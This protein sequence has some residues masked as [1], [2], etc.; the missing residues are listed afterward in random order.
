MTVH[1]RTWQRPTPAP[2]HPRPSTRPVLASTGGGSKGGRPPWASGRPLTVHR[3]TWQRP[4]PAP[5]HP[6]PS[7]TRSPR[8]VPAGGRR[9]VVPPGYQRQAE[10][11]C[12]A[13]TNAR[14]STPPAKH[15]TGPGQYRRGVEGGSS[16]LGIRKAVDRS[17]SNVHRRTWQRPTQ[18]LHTPAKHDSLSSRVPAGGEGGS[19]PLGIRGRRRHVRGNDQR[20]HIHTPGQAR[21]VLASTGGGSKGGRPPWVS[22]EGR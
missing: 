5:P 13:T 17:P 6:R 15:A 12:V 14:T 16:P 21:P 8:R 10:T 11:M 9:G 20:T 19:S 3:R 22:E 4:T 2:P 7:T 18:H 1:R